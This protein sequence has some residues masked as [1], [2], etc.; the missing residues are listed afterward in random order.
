MDEGLMMLGKEVRN[1]KKVKT[2][3]GV[4]L[5]IVAIGLGVTAVANRPEPA[6]EELV[7]T[8]QAQAENDKGKTDVEALSWEDDC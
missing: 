1:M 6:T 8:P 4:S 3:L 7:V 2:I 5:V